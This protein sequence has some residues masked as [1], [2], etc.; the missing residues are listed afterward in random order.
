MDQRIDPLHQ[1][2]IARSP[3]GIG[4]IAEYVE[5]TVDR[6]ASLQLRSEPDG[7]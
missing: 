7:L 3:E 4:L 2:A 5:D 1:L 6:L